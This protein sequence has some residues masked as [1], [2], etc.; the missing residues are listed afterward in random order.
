[1]KPEAKHT[2]NVDFILRSPQLDTEYIHSPIFLTQYT[3]NPVIKQTK[4]TTHRPLV[5][6]NLDVAPLQF[7][8][9]MFN[10]K[11]KA[12]HGSFQL[13][14]NF[15]FHSILHDP[16]VTPICIYSK[17]PCPC[18][19][20]LHIR[21]ASPLRPCNASQ[22]FVPPLEQIFSPR[23]PRRS[24]MGMSYYIIDWKLFSHCHWEGTVS[25]LYKTTRRCG[26][27]QGTLPSTR[28]MV[29]GCRV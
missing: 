5:P 8:F 15:P 21:E 11:H 9:S 13:M 28:F 23:P 14:F 7:H 26:K 19:P 6:I 12:P 25:N 1:M 18:L 20:L 29:F 2:H 27:M 24:E 10:P 22:R 4:T 3:P 16:H 17:I